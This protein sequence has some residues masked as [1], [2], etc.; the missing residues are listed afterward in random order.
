MVIS[1]KLILRSLQFHC[2]IQITMRDGC[3]NILTV[4]CEILSA[5]LP[6]DIYVEISRVWQGDSSIASPHFVL[7]EYKWPNLILNSFSMSQ[8]KTLAGVLPVMIYKF[9]HN[10]LSVEFVFQL[11]QAMSSLLWSPLR[12]K[13]GCSHIYTCMTFTYM[14]CLSTDEFTCLMVCLIFLGFLVI[15]FLLIDEAL[16][17]T[18]R[19]SPQVEQLIISF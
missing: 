5:A 11:Y 8:W 9:T 15:L 17:E 19:D 12:W 2:K 13:Q 3:N 14:H 4:S 10:I 6:Q 7:S 18:K 1:I 16:K